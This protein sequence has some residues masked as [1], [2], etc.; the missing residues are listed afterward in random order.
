MGLD[1]DRALLDDCARGL[2][3]LEDLP[4]PAAPPEQVVGASRPGVLLSELSR[5][6]RGLREELLRT[7]EQA[8]GALEGIASAFETADRALA[9]RAAHTQ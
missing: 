8:A 7:C 4:V 1:L 2:R 6:C 5:A 9:D 3:T